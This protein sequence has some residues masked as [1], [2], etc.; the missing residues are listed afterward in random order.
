MKKIK[1]IFSVKT[2]IILLC[3]VSIV[4]VIYIK[5]KADERQKLVLS[6]LGD[7]MD[8]YK[9]EQS[10]TLGKAL[11]YCELKT[12]DIDAIAVGVDL[13]GK[14]VRRY[15]IKDRMVVSKIVEKLDSM[16]VYEMI[17]TA[18]DFVSQ[19][20][21]WDIFVYP[22]ESKYALRFY[23]QD[24]KEDGCCQTTVT[25][26]N[27]KSYLLS[28]DDLT[29]ELTTVFGSSSQLMYN[30]DVIS[31][32]EDIIKEYITKISVDRIKVICQQEEINYESLFVYEHTPG[33]VGSTEV[34]NGL[35]N[36]T[37]IYQFPLQDNEGYLLLEKEAFI[38]NGVPRINLLRLE[39][40]NAEGEML[41]L[42]QADVEE[43]VPFVEGE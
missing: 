17:D 26:T 33:E 18:E 34:V 8:G 4:C 1:K 11:E 40:Y 21:S 6:R 3:I 7:T 24:T 37:M 22:Q 42:L 16:E 23:G 5:Y 27:K 32:I 15:Y 29:D 12:Y 35:G 25:A 41:D 2:F 13:D 10:G 36:A 39:L 20:V 19:D 30:T 31:F 43:I 14:C 28:L 9:G 38:G